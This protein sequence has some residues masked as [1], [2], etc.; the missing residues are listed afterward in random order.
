[1]RAFAAGSLSP[2]WWQDAV[3]YQ[4]YPRSFQ[5]SNGDGIGDLR[6][7]ESRLDHLAWLGVAALWMSPV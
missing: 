4:V 6:S 3:V 2:V 7:V 1:M 5:D